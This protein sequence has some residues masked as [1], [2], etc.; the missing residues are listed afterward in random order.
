MNKIKLASGVLLVFFVGVLAGSLG[1]GYYYKE[2]VKKFEERGGLPVSER[3]QV[4]LGRFSNDLNLTSEQRT[5]FEKIVREAQEKISA[6]EKENQTEIENINEKM[7]TSIKEKLTDEQKVKLEEMLKRMKNFRE[8]FLGGQRQQQRAPDQSRPQ[9]QGGPDQGPQQQGGP[10]QVPPQAA[11]QQGFP[12]GSTP[13]QQPGGRPDQNM[14][15]MGGE[16][17]PPQRGVMRLAGELKDRLNLTQEQ[18]Q[19]LMSVLE[20][21]IKERQQVLEK[22]KDEKA[23]SK[24]LKS[25]LQEKESAFEKKLSGILT[26]EQVEKYREEKKSGAIKI[27]PP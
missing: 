23:D 6:I 8:R 10:E 27:S 5:E 15:Q 22:Y 21:F 14:P 4:I 1:T 3:I 24:V 18:N 25:A 26:K 9:Q 11:P 20:E 17:V 16:S 2:R 19:K 7:F 13:Q 12:Q